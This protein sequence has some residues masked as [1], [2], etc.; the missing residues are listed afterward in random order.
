MCLSITALLFVGEGCT[1]SDALTAMEILGGSQGITTMDYLGHAAGS[2]T[3]DKDK[4]ALLDTGDTI[5]NIKDAAALEGA[6]RAAMVKRPPNYAGA[7]AN[8]EAAINLRPNDWALKDQLNTI[9][10]EQG[11]NSGAYWAS[12]GSVCV[13]EATGK[14][15]FRCWHAL[16]NQRTQLFEESLNRQKQ[17]DKLVSC[18][19]YEAMY[20]HYDYISRVTDAGFTDAQKDAFSERADHAAAMLRVPGQTCVK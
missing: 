18:T 13:D 6:A 19:T 1:T 12:P 7:V 8:L 17:T 5:K 11:G 20:K 3:G 15:N 4:D 14:G 16:V 10:A 2:A 9:R